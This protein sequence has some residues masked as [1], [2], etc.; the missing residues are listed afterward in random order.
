MEP[1]SLASLLLG[2]KS[3]DYGNPPQPHSHHSILDPG[4]EVT[5]AMIMDLLSSGNI[6]WRESVE[7][8]FNTMN[9]WLSIVHPELFA[10][11]IKGLGTSDIPQDPEVALLVVCMRLVTQYGE[12]DV[13]LVIEDKDMV[14]T[15]T[16]MAAKRILGLLRAFSKPSL[17]LIQCTVLLGLYEFGHGD[18][19]KAYVTI[20]DANT[21]ARTMGIQPGKYVDSERNTR[22]CFE[23]E[24]RRCVYWA[25]L[26]VDRYYFIP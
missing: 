25:L 23:E 17:E 4:F 24:E 26:V 13:P 14:L 7:L 3:S 11:K 5:S 12:G 9:P 22:I 1:G 15:P 21:L 6:T 10:L 19:M 2:A 20:G 18:A 16:Y 8:Y